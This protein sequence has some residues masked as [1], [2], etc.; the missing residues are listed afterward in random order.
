MA[1]SS[2]TKA[3]GVH[4]EYYIRIEHCFGLN[5]NNSNTKQTG[6]TKYIPQPEKHKTK[7]CN[8]CITRWCVVCT[9]Y[10]LQTDIHTVR[11]LV[12]SSYIC[13]P[14]PQEKR[15]ISATSSRLKHVTTYRLYYNRINHVFV[16]TIYSLIPYFR[17]GTLIPASFHTYSFFFLYSTGSRLRPNMTPP[18]ILCFVLIPTRL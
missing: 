11:T 18:P 10:V 8:Y 17:P 16:Q 13:A 9:L 15:I 4:S 1:F 3:W 14:Q 12:S 2:S 6:P 5:K 7:S